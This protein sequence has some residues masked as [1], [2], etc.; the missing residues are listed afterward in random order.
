MHAAVDRAG[1][2]RCAQR[3]REQTCSLGHVKLAYLEAG[4]VRATVGEHLRVGAPGG[5]IGNS[6]NSTEPH[7]PAE[8]MTGTVQ[9]APGTRK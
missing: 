9:R 8:P 3:S 2:L 6:G 5:A 7:P 4:S 1:A